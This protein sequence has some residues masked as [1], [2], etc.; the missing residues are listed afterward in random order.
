MHPRGGKLSADLLLRQSPSVRSRTP[1]VRVGLLGCGVVGTSVARVLLGARGLELHRVAV[2]RPG[3]SRDVTLPP[4]V[5]CGD[6][7]DVVHDPSVDVV[8]EAIG[9]VD[10]PRQLLLQALANGKSVVTA[11]KELL[12][13]HGRELALASQAT[14]ADLLFEGAVCAALP[15][16]SA[17]RDRVALETV[18]RV[19][20]VVNGTTNFVLELMAT[21][22]TQGQALAEARRRG[23]AEADPSADLDGSDAAAKLAILASLAF[24]GWVTADDV[25]REGIE[26]IGPADLRAAAAR[27]RSLKLVAD[28]TPERLCVRPTSVPQESS[29]A[30]V[31]GVDNEVT[32]ECSV[33]G[34]LTFRGPGAGGDAT[35]G[36]VAGD[37]LTA[38]RNLLAGR[39]NP[40]TT[41]AR[42]ANRGGVT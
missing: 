18:H 3:K 40:L 15:V 6:A 22:L 41:L 25:E 37:V 5:V 13:R 2:L 16:V 24:G 30:R 26:E 9:G 1:T 10:P 27:G 19:T 7:L 14:G 39:R 35:A 12:S 21:G 34:R 38:A 8:V 23:Y 36:A 28:A 4:D 31:A 11:N 42:P 33:S 29:L 32:L 17:L 20:G